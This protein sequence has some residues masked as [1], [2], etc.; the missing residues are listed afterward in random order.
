[1]LAVEGLG[2][3]WRDFRQ[4]EAL[5]AATAGGGK[6]VAVAALRRTEDQALVIAARVT[7]TRCLLV[8]AWRVGREA[9]AE[10]IGT[11]VSTPTETV[12]RSVPDSERAFK[13]S[14]A[15]DWSSRV[16]V[17][18]GCSGLLPGKSAQRK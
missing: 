18:T 4:R 16:S 9:Q 2:G 6:I 3:C 1:M 7:T 12:V 17:W 5:R 15:A 13:N 10:V 8:V 11:E 14:H